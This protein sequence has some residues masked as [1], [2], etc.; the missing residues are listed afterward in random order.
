MGVGAG[1]VNV[2]HVASFQ[3]NLGDSAMHDGAYRTRAEDCP[4]AFVYTPLEV[5]EFF[6]WKKRQFDAGFVDYLNTYDLAIFGGLIG[7]QLWRTDTAT[8]TC[9]DIAPELFEKID[10][11]VVFY[12]L[13]CDATRGIDEQAMVKC[14]RF[15]DIAYHK[16]FLF[17]LRNDG[18]R[19]ILER[20]VGRQY[21]EPMSVIADGGLFAQPQRARTE[22]LYPAQKLVAISLAGDM[23]DRRF[24]SIG[25]SD[26]NEGELPSEDEFIGGLVDVA[27]ELL[28]LEP[29]IRIV[30]VPHIYSDLE[31]IAKVLARMSDE[32]RRLHVSVAPYLNGGDNWSEI[33]DIYRQASLVIGMRFHAC[34][35]AMGQG[36]PVIGIDTHHKV[37]GLFADMQLDNYCIFLSNGNWCAQLV[38]WALDVLRCPVASREKGSERLALRRAG[39]RDFH[40][41]MSSWYTNW[42][43]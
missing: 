5:R 21:I 20:A 8:G 15:L 36:T 43:S 12:G 9:F 34:V 25:T 19:Q 10:V 13:G 32:Y 14:R 40:A 23:P 38:A 4:Q 6:H 33:F 22:W 1:N 37:G 3:G 27:H 29:D 41:K 39:L 28:R 35:V 31:I 2:L 16:D 18:S 17:S 42:Q 11:P 26:R 30:F 24:G 7:Y